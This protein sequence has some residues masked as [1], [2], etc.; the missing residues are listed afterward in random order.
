MVGWYETAMLPQKG[1]CFP[2]LLNGYYLDRDWETN[3]HTFTVGNTVLFDIPSAFGMRELDQKFANILAVTDDTITTDVNT[4]NFTPFS[5][6]A[7][8][9]QGAYAKPVG[10]TNTGFP[11]QGTIPKPIGIA[12]SFRTVIT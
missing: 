1:N 8:Y 6:P 7:S 5:V 2:L 4:S 9:F 12:G 3:N 10:D 11:I